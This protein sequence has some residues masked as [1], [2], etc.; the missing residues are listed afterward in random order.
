MLQT[1]SADTKKTTARGSSKSQPPRM[2][3]DGLQA[4]RVPALGNQAALRLM[5]KCDCGAPDCD[6]GD[7]RKKKTAHAPGCIARRS[8][9]G[10]RERRRPLSM[11]RCG[12]PAT[13]SPPRRRPSSRPVSDKGSA[14]FASTPILAH[15]SPSARAV[16][17]LAY[18]VGRD[19]VF[20]PGRY[21]PRANEGRRLLAHELAHVVQQPNAAGTPERVSGPSE[22]LKQDT[23]RVA[24]YQVMGAPAP[25][26]PPGQPF[27]SVGQPQSREAALRR[28]TSAP[29]RVQSKLEFGAS[30]DR[31]SFIWMS[32]YI[33]Q[34]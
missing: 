2:V 9:R 23:D 34:D 25:A 7:H 27:G 10:R 22:P 13:R 5:R 32:D 19:I 31:A 28:L 11:R 26:S 3:P 12:Q 16:N 21:A 18:T 8:R 29:L 15:R 14:T 6:M 1:A 33:R 17:A 30:L 24:S 4:P 20:A